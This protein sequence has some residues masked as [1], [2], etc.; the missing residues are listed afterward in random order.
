MQWFEEVADSEKDSPHQMYQPLVSA[1]G[2]WRR[3]LIGLSP[4]V[5]PAK[6]ILSS[7]CVRTDAAPYRLQS[8]FCAS[9][10]FKESI[11]F[12]NAETYGDR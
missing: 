4:S 9:S 3:P 5:V 2:G 6:P 1:K 10:I 7:D 8:A 12:T 11:A